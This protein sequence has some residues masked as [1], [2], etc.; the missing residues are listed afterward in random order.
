MR[1]KLFFLLLV[2]SLFAAAL[3]A[4]DTGTRT[5]KGRVV[6]ARDGE[7]PI[8]A[9][10]FIAPD[11]TAAKDFDPQGVKTDYDGN[12]LFTLPKSVKKVI[13][14]YIGFEDQT[15]ELKPD[16]SIYNVRLKENSDFLDELVVTGYQVIEK[17]KVTSA[18]TSIEA[19]ELQQVG[20]PSIDQLLIGQASGVVITPISGA[21]GAQS[22]VR[23]R[24]TV[25]LTGSSEPLWVLD[26][27]PLD[28]D[29][30]PKDI[31]DQNILDQLHNSSIAG[32]NPAD[33]EDITILKDAAATA[34]Y[35]AR[36][37][38]GVIVITSKRGKEGKIRVNFN[39]DLFHTARPIA[40]K[41]NLL[42]ASQK[43][44][45][46]LGLLRNP[47]H[48][49]LSEHGDVARLIEGA[50]LTDAYKADGMTA[51][52]PEVTSQL[53]HLRLVGTDWFGEIYA[54]TLNQQ[55]G[56]SLSGGSER[57]HYYT[58]FGYYDEKGT[59]KGTS[60]GRYNLTT[61]LDFNLSKKF[62]ASLSLFA[63]QSNRSTY[64]TDGAFANPQR[65]TRDVNPYRELYDK[66][67]NY[68]YDADVTN[69]D[70]KQ[71]PFNYA[72][73]MENTAYTL[74]NQSL[75][76]V[77]DLKWNVLESLRLTSQLGL[78]LE[79]NRTEKFADQETFF[80]RNYREGS[81]TGGKP[82]L[83]E[84]G[85]IQ[86][87]NEAYFQY[88]WKNQIFYSQVFG[89]KHDLDLMGGIELRKNKSTGI[90]GKGFGFDPKTLT[91]KPV[92]FPE[93]YSSINDARY[94]MY[95]KS[96]Y[97]NAFV[98]FF[99]TASYTYDHRYT[100]FASLR[101]D[102]SNL[103][104]VDPKYKYLPLWSVSGAWNVSRE[105]FMK[106]IK[107]IYDLKVR[108]SYGIQGNVDKNT[109]PFVKGVWGTK[110]FFT[111]QHVPIITV[112][113]PP[114]QNL[115]WEKT[116]TTNLGVDLS[117]LEGRIST[118]FDYYYR[119][120]SDL[121]SMKSIPRE[122]GFDF[123]SLNWGEVENRGWE[124]SLSTINIQTN[125]WYWSTSFNISRN[126]SKV[127][128]Y[129]TRDT[130]YTPSLEGY[131]INAIFVIPTAGL[132]ENGLM[133]FKGKDGTIKNIKEF[134]GLTEGVFGDVNSELS[135]AEYRDLFEY[136]G[137]RDPKLTGGISSTLKYKNW[138]LGI[139]SNFF[140]DKMVVRRPF[141]HPTKV[142]PG[143]NYTSEIY[144]IWSPDN[145]SGIYPKILGGND[146]T[147]LEKF[148]Y[149]WL[150]GY[151]PANSYSSYDIWSKKLSYL[152]ISSI[153]LGY[154]IRGGDVRADWF[155]RI[156][157]SVEA[158]NPFVISTDYSGYFDPE[159][160]GNIYA[161]PVARTV[162]FGVN[163]SF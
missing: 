82:V 53:D 81:K 48:N 135:E 129:N 64:L 138:D 140:I 51:L 58:S 156:R 132:D 161:Q 101:Y 147:E 112:L 90:H 85:I 21:P 70:Y 18:V 61:N 54:P 97:E 105:S 17:R 33:I 75:K 93:G 133:T 13:V 11:Q 37:A 160:Y 43:V 12:Y 91:T 30:V 28:G 29:Q 73:E 86:N 4:Q 87:W 69:S 72:E 7:P 68:I 126:K 125:D 20:V 163:M 71:I 66:D 65:Y 111:N 122:N 151:D 41:L 110:S 107:W 116:T 55:Y 62:Q 27:I 40:S 49:H 109:S 9:T 57:M 127:L 50:G 141:Y 154:T 83:P 152:R 78:Q 25:S 123:V 8:A 60:F 76:S 84:G 74:K 146:L 67:G 143:I 134:Y 39:A 16:Q 79:N 162:S 56:L 131:P 38:N 35:G 52:S 45:L 32:L 1:R 15:I 128:Q 113:S 47:Y 145:T 120:S 108:A 139:Y 98:S 6:D 94:R 26:G 42:N 100:L 31:S 95:D 150:N 36:A 117:L 159:S 5:I 44:D 19:D 157:F 148:T 23:I 153:R 142:D 46:E 92:V 22:Q 10:V 2:T 59:T 130:D 149:E 144:D 3:P 124:L 34:I 63:N 96:V 137:D 121:I 77:I 80:T 88:N 136:A 114:N 14:S 158:R 102:G 24:G 119:N 99:S 89:D 104:G 106:P 115:R 103:F 118:T 155:D